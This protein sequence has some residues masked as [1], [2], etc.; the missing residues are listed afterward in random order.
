MAKR[1][2]LSVIPSAVS[3]VPPPPHKLQR[4]G[5]RLWN[6][7]LGDFQIEDPAGREILL[8]A[9]IGLDRAEALAKQ[10]A[11]DGA[12]IRTRTGPRVH[13]AIKEE[14]AARSFAMRM[15]RAL[16][17]DSEPLKLVGRPPRPQGI[18]FADN[19]SDDEAAMPTNRTPIRRQRRAYTVT[20]HAIRLYG[21][22]KQA[23]ADP[24]RRGVFQKRAM[25]LHMALGRRPWHVGVFDLDLYDEENFN[26]S[27]DWAGAVKLR[28]LLEAALTAQPPVA[29]PGTP[30][31][32]K[33]KPRGST[34]S[35]DAGG[36]AVLLARGDTG[37]D[38]DG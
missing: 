12:S 16:G 6:A 36:P 8:Q 25:D 15:L 27:H 34:P 7:I 20:A 2:T 18:G 4:H 1:P 37:R 28:E 35:A 33:P 21:L 26:D 29:K 23:Q 10:I 22:A 38:G 17:L 11:L 3:P 24:D 19:T 32:A 31:P 14:L 30:Q 9:C 13:P 5:L